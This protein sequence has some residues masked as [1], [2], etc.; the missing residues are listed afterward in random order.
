MAHSFTLYKKFITP[1]PNTAIPPN[2]IQQTRTCSPLW[3]IWMFRFQDS[4]RFIQTR[5]DVE[6]DVLRY[7]SVVRLVW[8]DVSEEHIDSVFRIQRKSWRQYVN[9][10][11]GVI[12][13]KMVLFITTAV[14]T[15]NH[16]LQLNSVALFRQR[17]IPTERPPLVGE[18][19]PTFADSGQRN[20]LPR[21]LISVF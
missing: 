7:N 13:Q 15:S 8:A 2:M 9:G 17:T 5:S 10:P 20:G 14:R 19:V 16:K 18:V 11:H 1:I 3:R 4:S 12:S 21:P 6:N